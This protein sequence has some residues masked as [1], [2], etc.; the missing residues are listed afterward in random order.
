MAEKKQPSNGWFRY[1]HDPPLISF[2]IPW[3]A[4]NWRV[5]TLF[6]LIFFLLGSILGISQTYSDCPGGGL[7]RLNLGV[8]ALVS[9]ALLT[10]KF[11]AFRTKNR[12]EGI[13]QKIVIF[14]VLAAVMALVQNFLYAECLLV[15]EHVVKDKCVSML[16]GEQHFH[17]AT[18]SEEDCYANEYL[19][20]AV[21]GLIDY[22]VCEEV[23]L[24]GEKFLCYGGY[25]GYL[26]NDA[27]I[28]LTKSTE[29]FSKEDCFAMFAVSFTINHPDEASVDLCNNLEDA[30]YRKQCIED[31]ESRLT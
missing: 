20:P 12:I 10:P 16:E 2:S 1:A 18:S 4:R 17:R 3:I 25:A 28:C 19:A 14:I 13:P 11:S 24:E 29:K 8:W 21:H 9:F 27:S 31:V 6:V 15:S 7:M 22:A 23:V 5:S 26:G 30:Q